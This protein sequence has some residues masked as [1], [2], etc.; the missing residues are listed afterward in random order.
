MRVLLLDEKGKSPE[1]GPM[2]RTNFQMAVAKARSQWVIAT[3]D[4]HSLLNLPGHEDSTTKAGT[5]WIVGWGK[6]MSRK[7]SGSGSAAAGH[8]RILHYAA[9]RRSGS[10]CKGKGRAPPFRSG[11]RS[12]AGENLPPYATDRTR[13]IRHLIVKEPK[14]FFLSRFPG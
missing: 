6:P 12:R 8:K 1:A 5:R 2:W 13:N 7:L 3:P 14:F 4:V 11:W 10:T 9:E